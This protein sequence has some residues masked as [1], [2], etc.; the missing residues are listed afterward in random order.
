MGRNRWRAPEGKEDP[1]DQAHEGLLLRDLVN[2]LFDNVLRP[3]GRPHTTQEVT[4]H[5]RISH[6]TINQLRTGRSKNPTLPTLQELCR[7]F[8]VPLSFFE[9][10]TYDECYA[11]LAD[12]PEAQTEGVAEIAFRASRLSAQAQRDILKV[13]QWVEAAERERR[14]TDKLPDLVGELADADEAGG[15]SP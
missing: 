12:K 3:D 11:V 10:Q 5:V 7:F 6:A 14:E 8:E 1:V 4:D 15:V 9:C 2:F 13:I